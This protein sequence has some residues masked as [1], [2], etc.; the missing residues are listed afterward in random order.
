MSSE[1][2]TSSKRRYI[3]E[4]RTCGVNHV[5]IPHFFQVYKRILVFILG[6]LNT[7]GSERERERDGKESDRVMV[8]EVLIEE[9]VL[10]RELVVRSY[11]MVL[12]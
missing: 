11:N 3:A 7:W 9:S 2:D 5:V 12:L 1:Y 4:V 8:L 6:V 10:E